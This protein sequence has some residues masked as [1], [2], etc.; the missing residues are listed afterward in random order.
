M[1]SLTLRLRLML[2]LRLDWHLGR[3]GAR[4]V[5]S[6]MLM[7]M[8]RRRQRLMLTLDWLRS[9]DSILEELDRRPVIIK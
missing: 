3:V 2:R 9:G 5:L 7:L 1:L 8:L 6:L 4:P